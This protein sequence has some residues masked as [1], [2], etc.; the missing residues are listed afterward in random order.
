MSC[1]YD[2]LKWVG[3]C[4]KKRRNKV[5]LDDACEEA[6]IRPQQNQNRQILHEKE[7]KECQVATKEVL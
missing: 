1:C 3:R 7:D 4:L 6:E 5:A 2:C